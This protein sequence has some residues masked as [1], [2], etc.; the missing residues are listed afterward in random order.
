MVP[1]KIKKEYKGAKLIR[2]II[3]RK[4]ITKFSWN[5]WRNSKEK[6]HIS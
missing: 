4:A 3:Y 2:D 1:A 6:K 5:G